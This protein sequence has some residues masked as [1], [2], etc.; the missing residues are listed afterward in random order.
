MTWSQVI[1]ESVTGNLYDWGENLS[2]II[3]SQLSAPFPV[4]GLVQDSLPKPPFI[5]G[6]GTKITLSKHDDQA[7]QQARSTGLSHKQAR[8]ITYLE[9]LRDN[10][11]DV[12]AKLK[13]DLLD[14]YSRVYKF[15]ADPKIV[16]EGAK[17]FF[18][19]Y[20]I[21]SEDVKES[22]GSFTGSFVAAGN[23][24][25]NSPTLLIETHTS[26]K[27]H[28]GKVQIWSYSQE[29][30]QASRVILN[31]IG[32]KIDNL[33]DGIKEETETVT[34]E[35]TTCGYHLNWKTADENGWIKC[36]A[37]DFSSQLP[38]KYRTK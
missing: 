19:G 31:D 22:N 36:E 10:V 38:L 16:H 13:A 29:E 32:P 37:C 18:I 1:R 28:E 15:D 4:E 26:G 9:Q 17:Q 30:G 3:P 34:L 11:F 25:D 6:E 7:I 35:C 5:I 2:F 20:K 27:L 24:V 21:I 8:A 12:L 33:V 14:S 23:Y